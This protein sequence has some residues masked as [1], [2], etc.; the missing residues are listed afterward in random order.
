MIPVPNAPRHRD[1]AIGGPTHRIDVRA[2]TELGPEHTYTSSKKR[3]LC[4]AC[5]TYPRDHCVWC[6]ACPTTH[7]RSCLVNY[8]WSLAI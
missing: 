2:A 8:A 5:Q 3:A 6:L 7:L 1:R 4:A